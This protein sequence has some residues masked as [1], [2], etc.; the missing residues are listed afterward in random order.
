MN[1]ISCTSM[2]KKSIL[3][4]FQR[5]MVIGVRWSDLSISKTD[6][7]LGFLHTTISTVYREWSEKNSS[8]RKSVVDKSS[9]M[10]GQFCSSSWKGNCNSNNQSL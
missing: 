9:E 10:N 1:S 6:N 2:E 3:S 5:C 7:L 4:D 8:E